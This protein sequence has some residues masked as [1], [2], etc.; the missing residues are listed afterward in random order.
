MKIC[1][2]FPEQGPMGIADALRWRYESV[3]RIGPDLLLSLVPLD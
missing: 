1:P 2:T 3:Q